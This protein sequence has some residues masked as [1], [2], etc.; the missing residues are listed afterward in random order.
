MASQALS[1]AQIAAAI[2]KKRKEKN[3]PE[4]TS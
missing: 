3:Q 4:T 1:S 2:K